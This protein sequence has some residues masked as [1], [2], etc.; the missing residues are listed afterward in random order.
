MA[1]FVALVAT[2]FIAPLGADHQSNGLPDKDAF[3]AEA[4]K[5]LAGN[6][7]LQSRFTYRERVTRVRFNPLGHIGTGPVDV[8]EVYPVDE[9]LRYRRLLE[10]NGA[11]VPADEIAEADRE[12]MARYDAWRRELQRE[13]QDER[14]ARLHRLAEEQEKDR[15]RA[16]EA[17]GVFDFALERRDVLDGQPVIV[18]SFRPKPNARPQGREAKIASSFAGHAYVH[19]HEH[20]V[21]RVEAEAITDTSFGYGVI[22]K[23]HKGAK[24][25]A[26]RRKIGDVWLPVETR[27][28]GT[29]RAFLF[30]KV[31]IDYVREYLDYRPFEPSELA[32]LLG[33]RQK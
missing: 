20:Q 26:R 8:Y 9:N 29:G 27:M 23:L 5:R 25:V 12:F 2:V 33:L 1:A 7:V 14:A 3:L 21:M 18:V 31:N 16:E 19:E 30:R 28:T 22:A 17:I 4:R 11:P 32:T 15:K 13:G 10:R 24:A 6:E